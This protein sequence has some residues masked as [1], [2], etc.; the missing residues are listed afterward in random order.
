MIIPQIWKRHGVAARLLQSP[1]QFVFWL[2]CSI[3]V[4]KTFWGCQAQATIL[5]N[6]KMISDNLRAKPTPKT[7]NIKCPRFNNGSKQFRGHIFK[8]WPWIEITVKSSSQLA[9]PRR[10]QQHCWSKPKLQGRTTTHYI[11]VPCF[12]FVVV[13]I[14]LT[15]TLLDSWTTLCEKQIQTGGSDI[16][17]TQ[18]PHRHPECQP[19]IHG[20]KLHQIRQGRCRTRKAPTRL[21][22]HWFNGLHGQ[23]SSGWNTW[24]D[25]RIQNW[26]FES[27]RLVE[28]ITSRFMTTDCKSLFEAVLQNHQNL[29]LQNHRMA[30]VWQ[31]W[32][33]KWVWAS[34]WLGLVY[35]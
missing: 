18:T 26:H 5:Y 4:L 11:K 3:L 20:R 14:T 6:E 19:G 10:R 15:A 16:S 17:W 13:W 8:F 23:N 28:C 29:V 34:W 9:E 27:R 35:N 7:A 32:W 31:C 22:K 2:K 25:C 1:S 30:I 21:L 24:L 33:K 12:L